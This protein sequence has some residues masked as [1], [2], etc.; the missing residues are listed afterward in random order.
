MGDVDTKVAHEGDSHVDVE[1]GD[2]SLSNKDKSRMV[3]GIW[4]TEEDGGDVLQGGGGI[5]GEGTTWEASG[6]DGKG[7]ATVS[8]EVIDVCG[9]L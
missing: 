6:G 9:S 5:E 7:E 4:C 1:L 8:A 3:L 2:D